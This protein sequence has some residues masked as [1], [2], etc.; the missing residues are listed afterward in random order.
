MLSS[1]QMRSLALAAVPGRAVKVEPCGETGVPAKVAGVMAGGVATAGCTAA[2]VDPL[3]GLILRHVLMSAAAPVGEMARAEVATTGTRA[4]GV[5][6]AHLSR[7][8]AATALIEAA[9]RA[10]KTRRGWPV[11]I[12]G[13]DGA[14]RAPMGGAQV[15]KRA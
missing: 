15:G 3:P 10:R 14:S 13:P 5:S 6:Y 9:V 2:G 4:P 11:C 8:R 1:I 7:R 12:T